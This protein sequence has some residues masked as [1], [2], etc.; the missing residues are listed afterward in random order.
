MPPSKLVYFPEEK[1]HFLNSDSFS[2][3]RVIHLK[4]YHFLYPND[5]IFTLSFKFKRAHYKNHRPSSTIHTDEPQQSK[6]KLLSSMEEETSKLPLP[7]AF[8]DF[9][10]TNEIDP[11]I[12]TAI[13]STPRYIR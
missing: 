5:F 9:L 8:L 12:Y 2:R 10:Q 3:R 7:D 13:E 4:T 11:L 6:Q 1:K